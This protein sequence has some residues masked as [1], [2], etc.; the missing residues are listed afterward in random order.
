MVSQSNTRSRGNPGIAIREHFVGSTGIA[1][2]QALDRAASLVALLGIAVLLARH[3]FLIGPFP[4]GLDGAQWLALGRGFHGVGRSTD[5]AYA[6]LTPLL[7]TMAEALLGPLAAL[8]LLALGS[9]LAVA[10]VIWLLAKDALGPRWGLLAAGLAIPASALAEPLMYGGYP[11]QFALAAGIVSLWATC[12]YLI[13]GDARFLWIMGISAVL[14][15]AAHHIYF[16][17][18]LLSMLTAMLIWLSTVKAQARWQVVRPL[19]LALAPACAVLA[20]VAYQFASSGYQAPL[21]ASERTLWDGLRYATREAPLVWLALVIAAFAS[22]ALLWRNRASLAWLS[23]AGLILPAGSLFLLSGQPRLLPPVL[24]GTCL[25]VALGA[26]TLL[27]RQRQIRP[28]PLLFVVAVAITLLLSAD[29]ATV[30]FAEFYRVVDQPLIEAS[31][32]IARDRGSGAVAVREDRRG[33]PIGWWF[34]ALLTQPVIVGSDPRWL[35][36]PSEQEHAR[37]AAALFDGGL[38][39]PTFAAL[40]A[41]NDVGYLVVPKWDWIGWERWL[42]QPEFPVTVLHDDDRY[43]VLRVTTVTE[44]IENRGV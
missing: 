31:A 30:G 16:P 29:R 5:G 17:L 44:N 11:Q 20:V 36:F 12:R 22:L 10:L 25:A 32:A 28:L 18:I 13:D 35:G 40:A 34:E 1:A 2:E 37:Q 43:L 26:K 39:P 15:S 14:C 42:R 9:G 23:A 21:Q 33:W 19:A 6:P 7:A 27:S 24:I 41:A 8:R 3:W 4:P 38:D